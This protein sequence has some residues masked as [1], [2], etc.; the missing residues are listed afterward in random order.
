MKAADL[1]KSILQYAVE[2]KLVQQNIHDEPAYMLYDKIIK[3]KENLIKQGKIKKE[4]PLPTITDDE[5]PYDIPNNWKWVRLGEVCNLSI[6]KTPERKI[7]EYWKDG[8]YNWVSISDMINGGLINQ[9]KE[10]ISQ[11]AYNKVFKKDT[12]PIGTLLFSFKLTIGKV[13]L[14]N[15]PAYTNEAI[16]AITPYL[17]D[18]IKHYLLKILPILNLLDNANDAIKGKTLNLQTLPLILLPLPPLKEQ[19]RIV[20]KV[21]ELMALCDKLEQEEEKLLSLDKHFADTLPK[22]I[23]QYAVEGKLMQ[24]NIHDEPAS[25]LYDK[26]IK[27]K[28]NLIK[29]GK[30]KK[31]KPLPPIT[32]DDIPYDIPN[33]WKWVRL[34]EVCNLLN[35]NKITNTNLP[36]LNAKYL[37][38]RQEKQMYTEG[39]KVNK[40][41]YIILVDGEN[42]GEVFRAFE[43]GILGSTFKILNINSN[44]YNNYILYILYFYKDTFKKSKKGAAIPHLDKEL[45]KNILIPLPPLKEQERIVKKV[46]ELLTCCNK[47]KNII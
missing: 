23:L 42:S 29:Q 13:S 12:L 26:I 33:N 7:P 10:K 31:E 28:E 24:Q 36:L 46:D 16:C 35:G 38:T 27:E 17:Y 43:D 6:G 9:T 39:I 20:K 21:D 41:D 3:E 47:L 34:G 2:G 44:L 37:R 14:L 4:K 8:I 40:H 18:S 25:I 11:I 15:I 45:F 5:I 32:D 22:S 30:I 1:R 19:E